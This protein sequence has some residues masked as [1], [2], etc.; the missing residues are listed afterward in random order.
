MTGTPIRA[1]T[2]SSTSL[3]S[4]AAPHRITFKLDKSYLSTKELFDRNTINGG[5]TLAVLI[6]YF[7]WIW[8]SKS[9]NVAIKAKINQRR[10]CI[11]C[12]NGFSRK[13]GR[14]TTRTLRIALTNKVIQPNPWNQ[15]LVPVIIGTGAT[16]ISIWRARSLKL[17][18]K[19][20]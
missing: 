13:F 12:K 19:I 8:D 11:I 9:N 6:L 10:T 17:K 14:N 1:R 7:W 15:G 4:G 18:K 2:A 5:T 16:S 3:L 20:H